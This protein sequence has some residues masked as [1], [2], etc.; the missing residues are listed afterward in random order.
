MCELAGLPRVDGGAATVGGDHRA[1]IKVASGKARKTTMVA[2]SLGWATRA[3]DQGRQA[4][5]VPL[6]VH[7]ASF[8]LITSTMDGAGLAWASDT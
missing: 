5:E 4:F 1:A 7:G 2:I 6:L 8:R 3:G